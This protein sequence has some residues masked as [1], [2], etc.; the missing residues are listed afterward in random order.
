LERPDAELIHE[1][2][3]L[4]IK[5]NSPLKWEL[6]QFERL[7][8]QLG[9]NETTCL[10][11]ATVA[12]WCRTHKNQRFIPEAVLRHFDLTVTHDNWGEESALLQ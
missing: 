5:F 8:E 11:S 3:E 10:S 4:P 1:L 9:L 6:S 7:L 2:T 12:A